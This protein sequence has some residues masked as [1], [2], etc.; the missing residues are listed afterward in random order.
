MEYKG[1]KVLIFPD[2]T[3]EVMSQRC[4]FRDVMKALR[5]V[6][7]KHHLRHPARL[8]VYWDEEE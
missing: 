5:D 3:N 4:A 2:Y 7:V 8:H 1:N 6:G